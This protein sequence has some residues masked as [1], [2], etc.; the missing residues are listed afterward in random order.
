MLF[1]TSPSRTQLTQE[2]HVQAQEG[3]SHSTISVSRQGLLW[4]LRLRTS[5]LQ[6]AVLGDADTPLNHPQIQTMTW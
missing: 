1:E 4:L 3:I 2:R 5:Q 6:D